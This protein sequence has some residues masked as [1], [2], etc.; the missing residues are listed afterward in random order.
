MFVRGGRVAPGNILGGAGYN[1]NYWSSVGRS[2][3]I[4]YYLNF[5]SSGVG[6][7]NVDSRYRGF[8][9]R[10]VALGG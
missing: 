8:S 9:V 6:P 10:C 1:G 5:Y 7:S 2:S 4:A 3:S